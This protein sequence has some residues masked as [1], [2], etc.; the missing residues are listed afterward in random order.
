MA[1]IRKCYRIWIPVPRLTSDNGDAN[2]ALLLPEA[3]SAA[4]AFWMGQR[5]KL[6]MMFKVTAWARS[7][8]LRPNSTA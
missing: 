5:L 8:K 3:R 2:V 1:V 7:R 4:M 6:A